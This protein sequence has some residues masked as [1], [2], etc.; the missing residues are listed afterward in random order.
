MTNGAGEQLIPLTAELVALCERK[1][2]D[3]GPEPGIRYFDESAYIEAAANI[4]NSI[5][6][7]EF[8]VFAYGSLLWRP[9]A[10]RA[11]LETRKAR[12]PGWR[13]EFCMEITRWRGSS[14]TPGLMMALRKGGLCE[15][16]A[17]RL[18]QENLLA[19]LV[20]LLKREVD[21][22]ED[23]SGVAWIDLETAKGPLRAL[24]FWAEPT[25]SRLFS[26]KPLEEQA[27]MIAHACGAIGSGAAYLYR[28]VESLRSIGLADAYLETLSGLVAREI[29]NRH[30][31]PGV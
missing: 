21:T 4:L 26:E 16:M 1:V 2:P 8:W 12:A 19:D 31:V 11:P 30:L 22:E 6:H 17:I 7:G 9:A 15:G 27:R 3:P 5:S 24:S 25:G 29:Q 20:S 18:G 13:R 23:L 28:T 10:T 14:A